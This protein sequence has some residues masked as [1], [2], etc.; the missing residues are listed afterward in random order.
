MN[1]SAVRV[2]E[3]VTSICQR[4]HISALQPFLDSCRAFATETT[5]NVAI[6]GRFKTGKSSFL[7]QLVGREVLPIGVVPVTAVVTELEYGPQERAE[8]RFLDGR[9][10]VVPMESVAEFM[11]EAQNP[12]NSKRVSRVQL[13]LPS[14][15]R[16]AGL[17]FVDTPGLFSVFEHNTSVSLDWLPNVGLA[18]VA[19][20]IDHPLSQDDIEFIRK[21]SRYTP[22]ISLL[23]TK[24]DLLDTSQRAEVIEFVE[25]Q[26]QRHLHQRVEVFPYS[27][28]PGFNSYRTQLDKLLL[29]QIEGSREQHG[30]ILSHKLHSLLTECSDYLNVALKSA[31]AADAERQDFKAKVLGQKETLDETRLALRLIVRH[32]TAGLRSEFE[33]ILQPHEAEL[34]DRLQAELL[35]TFPSWTR[36]LN[37]T[38]DSIE[39]WAEGRLADVMGELSRLHRQDFLE[40]LERTGRQLSR[41][42]QD[43]RGRL[44]ARVLKTLGIPL[45][46]AEMNIPTTEPQFPDIRVG[47]IFDHNWELLSFLIPMSVAGGAVKK[48]FHRKIGHLVFVNISR[49]VSQWDD[50]ISAQMKSLE[51]ESLRRLESFIST[52]EGLMGPSTNTASQVHNDIE[53]LAR[54]QKLPTQSEL[55]T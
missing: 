14:M 4:Y 35:E 6:L 49:L 3:T 27:I 7:N 41:T 32:A 42:L 38:T 2:L 30:A 33:K 19:V 11:T 50:I 23:L 40:A 12:E 54:L 39:S 9:I 52:V 5:L 45:R 44:S 18:L 46:T 31:E 10:A 28:R 29:S 26:L 55:P 37:T 53:T 22:R 51:M 24:I 21:L 16:Y 36:S 13:T 48:H 8:V 25:L 15:I 43:F 34:R 47:K 17:R 20:A 1:D